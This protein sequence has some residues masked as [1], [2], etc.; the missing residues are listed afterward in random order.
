M[1]GLS[2]PDAQAHIIGA[3]GHRNGDLASIGVRCDLQRQIFQLRRLVLLDLAAARVDVLLEKTL[4]IQQSDAYQRHG[5]VGRCL[6]M[7]TGQDSQAPAVERQAFVKTELEAEIRDEILFRVEMRAQ[8]CR[9]L[10]GVI[11]VVRGDHALISIPIRWIARGRIEVRLGEAPQKDTEVAA[12][13]FVQRVVQ[14]A[15]QMP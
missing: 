5:K 8:V 15:E 9:H 1:A 4:V 12:A 2:A 6:A 11:G 13:G 14:L 10:A 3:Y 7:V